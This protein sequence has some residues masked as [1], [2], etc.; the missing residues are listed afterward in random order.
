MKSTKEDSF[1]KTSDISLV[2]T[3]FCFG[4]QIEKVDK[5]NPKRAIFYI[6]KDIGLK[7]VVQGFQSR[8]LQVEPWALLHSYKEVKKQLFQEK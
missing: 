6:K 5:T 1:Y 7:N 8:S 3:I 4:G 2:T